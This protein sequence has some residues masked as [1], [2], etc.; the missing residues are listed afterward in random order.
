M[1]KNTPRE[2]APSRV[3]GL[4]QESIVDK[5]LQLLVA[6]SRVRGLKQPGGGKRIDHLQSHPHGCVD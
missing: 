5:L 6:P 4:K 1:V 2:V 3:R